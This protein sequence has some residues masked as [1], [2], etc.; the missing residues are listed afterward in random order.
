MILHVLLYLMERRLR[1]QLG[2]D[3]QRFTQHL[4][5]LRRSFQVVQGLAEIELSVSLILEVSALLCEGQRCPL[6]FKAGFHL[7]EHDPCLA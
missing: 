7:S 5:G 2:I 1:G 4:L 6:C 3:A